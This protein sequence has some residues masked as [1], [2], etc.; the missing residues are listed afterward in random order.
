MAAKTP[1]LSILIPVYN[2]QATLDPLIERLGRALDLVAEPAEILF[3]NDGSTDE[4]AERL[5]QAR[6]HDARIRIIHFSRNFGH[7]RAIT[8]GI[9]L[10]AG[11][12]CIIM[13]GDL[14]DPPE[15]IPELVARWKAGYDVV[16]AVREE[17]A[18]AVDA[19]GPSV[20]SVRRDQA[21]QPCRPDGA[22]WIVSPTMSRARGNPSLVRAR[23]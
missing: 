8:A 17:L 4:T 5:R 2:E 3:V 6:Q 15:V 10:A 23:V 22:P 11:A 1:R 13:D 19:A 14:Q 7:Q 21:K 16:H 12:A 9:D 18:A 20:D